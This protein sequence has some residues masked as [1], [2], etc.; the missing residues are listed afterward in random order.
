[1]QFE[2]N[3]RNIKND[4]A[5]GITRS[6]NAAFLKHS[7]GKPQEP[8]FVSELVKSIPQDI[9]NSLKVYAPH[10]QFAVS[11]IFCHQKPL[12]NFGMGSK[13]EL[14]DIL[15]VYIEENKYAVKKCNALLLQAKKVDKAPY[16]VPYA[17]M[18]QLKLY[19]K[20][21]KFTL[22]RAGVFSG[23]EI[24]IQPKT[25]NTGA[26]FLLFQAPYKSETKVCCA[27]PDRDLAP[28]KKLSDQIVDLMKFF[29]GRTF[30]YEEAL[31]CNDDW[32]KLIWDLIRVSGVSLY[33]RRVIGR[34]NEPRR[35]SYGDFS[36]FDEMNGNLDIGDYDFGE[37]AVSC[38]LIYA[39]E[40]K[41]D[42]YQY[43]QIYLE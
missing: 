26:Q 24:D 12:A 11:G 6:M 41:K 17:N 21:P 1:M 28:E 18:P 39:K 7:Y 31:A 36:M 2:K 32:T 27:Y 3:E 42:F 19:E 10:Y 43:E 4:I 25:L 16:T 33:N 35:T 40:E 9:Y 20:W 5:N 34:N 22:E 13:S 23:E 30:L 37:E 29:T 38:L 15:L 8:D 14:G